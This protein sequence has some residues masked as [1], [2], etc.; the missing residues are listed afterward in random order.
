MYRSF[1]HIEQSLLKKITPVKVALVGAHDPESLRALLLASEKHLAEPIL[2][3]DRT[4]IDSALLRLGLP[5]GDFSIL[6]T[7]NHAQTVGQALSLID[8][9]KADILMKGLIPSAAVLRPVVQHAKSSQEQPFIVSQCCVFEFQHR[10]M[11]L[12]DCAVNISPSLR[13]KRGIIDNAVGVYKMLGGSI[14]HVSCLSAIETPTPSI[15]SSMAAQHLAQLPW[16]NCTV[17][18][19]IALDAALDESAAHAK[20][21]EADTAK[22]DILI[23]QDL[24]A[25]NVLYKSLQHISACKVGSILAGTDIPTVFPSRGDSGASKYRSILLALLQLEKVRTHE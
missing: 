5:P 16:N 21:M 1:A 8:T 12:S 25:G 20:G 17:S 22:T 2:I 19:P 10:L 4:L 18:G 11:L 24:D 3:G 13:D 23:A 15:P 9:G 7:G 14:P 6:D